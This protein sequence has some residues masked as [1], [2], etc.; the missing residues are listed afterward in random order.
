MGG[1]VGRARQG[2]GGGGSRTKGATQWVEGRR[3]GHQKVTV[4]GEKN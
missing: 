3:R 4:N 2:G 1:G